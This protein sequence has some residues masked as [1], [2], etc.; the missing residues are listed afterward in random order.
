MGLVEYKT[1][2]DLCLFLWNVIPKK[3]GFVE[4]ILKGHVNGSNQ[5]VDFEGLVCQPT[6][7]FGTFGAHRGDIS[8]AVN[9][10]L[11]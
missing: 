9:W 4:W 5:L 7:G 10:P 3:N 2:T 8:K 6:S 11:K 1:K